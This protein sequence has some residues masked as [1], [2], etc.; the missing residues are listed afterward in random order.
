MLKLLMEILSPLI[1]WCK[2]P[3]LK[4]FQWKLPDKTIFNLSTYRFEDQKRESISHTS[5]N[6]MSH[7]DRAKIQKELE[8]AMEKIEAL[9]SEL[10]TAMSQKVTTDLEKEQLEKEL[11]CGSISIEALKCELRISM[12]Q[13]E[14][15]DRVKAELTEK[16][17]CA[18]RNI[19]ILKSK[20][21]IEYERTES[22]GKSNCW[23]KFRGF[24]Q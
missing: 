10:R 13:N 21:K 22:E 12:S 3:N 7:F 23:K 6:E 20:L 17:E 8:C 19:E 16:L 2:T 15:A 18:L 24:K 11:A 4:N 1:E 14:T 9:K 5:R